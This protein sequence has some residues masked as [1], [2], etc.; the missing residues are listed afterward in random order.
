M[1]PSHRLW[2]YLA[3]AWALV[4]AAPHFYW[5]TGAEA[6]LRTALSD[7][8]VSEAGGGFQLLN[9][10]IGLFVTAGAATALATLR[11][12]PQ[13]LARISR[14]VLVGLL[15]FGAAVLTLRSLDIYVEFQLALTEVWDVPDV[16]RDDYLSMA[17]WFMFFWL[18]WF[19]LGALAWTR[20]AWSFTR[21]RTHAAA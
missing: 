9:L 21:S 15:W 17:R 12:W 6:G 19:A 2:A 14:R 8:I 1:N 4:F 20:L 18:P 10:G 16:D 5:A 11:H 7:E 13:Q 3:A